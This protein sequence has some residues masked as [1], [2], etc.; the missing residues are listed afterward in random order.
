MGT[1]LV[2]DL[3]QCSSAKSLCR[4]A[5]TRILELEGALKQVKNWELPDTHEYCED[6]TQKSYSSQHGSNGERD[7]MKKLAEKALGE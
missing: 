6:G 1:R 3:L 7:Y 2:L 5:A 4:Q